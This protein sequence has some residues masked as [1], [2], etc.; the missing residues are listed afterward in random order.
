KQQLENL[1]IVYLELKNNSNILLDFK[2]LCKRLDIPLI[3]HV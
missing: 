2:K 1:N 3:N